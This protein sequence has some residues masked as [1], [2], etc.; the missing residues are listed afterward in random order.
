MQFFYILLGSVF[1]SWICAC[2]FRYKN[3]SISN[4]KWSVCPH[5]LHRLPFHQM[6]PVFSWIKL[7][8]HCAWCH[9]EIPSETIVCELLGALGFFIISLLFDGLKQAGMLMI[10][11]ALLY[12]SVCDYLYGLIPDRTHLW[13][14]L[15]A[16]LI[17]P[18]SLRV[19]QFL[20]SLSLFVLFF[21]IASWTQAMGMG[22]GKL[23]SALAL[24]MSP[25]GVCCM[26]SLASVLAI[27]VSI[28]KKEFRRKHIIRFGP[29]LSTAAFICLCFLKI[30]P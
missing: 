27:F 4:E 3:Q 26:L 16:S 18:S 23:I 25:F 20:F 9:A 17:L 28:I 21:F 2:A 5:C 11:C 22:D 13:I 12:A 19:H 6:I 30:H 24:I 15:S 1:A 14:A 10:F 7:K 29:Y 8:G